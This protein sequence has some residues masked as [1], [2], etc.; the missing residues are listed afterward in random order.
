MTRRR[1]TALFALLALALAVPAQAHHAGAMFDSGKSVTLNG[2][3]R[4]FQWT[5]PHCF[6]QLL[7][8]T[9]A[10]PVEWS[11]EMGAPI[12]L[13]RLGWSKTTLKPGDK[14]TITVHPLQD[15]GKGGLFLSGLDGGGQKLGG[16][17]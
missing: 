17:R 11:I 13:K 6:I 9:P 16:S 4:E 7:Q 14:A 3:V 8:T 2:T 1:S 10:G 5:S 15:G 12:Q